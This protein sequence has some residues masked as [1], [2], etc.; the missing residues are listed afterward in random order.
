MEAVGPDVEEGFGVGVEDVASDNPGEED[1]VV[2]L[3]EL[4]DDL[5]VEEGQGAGQDGAALRLVEQGDAVEGGGVGLEAPAEVPDQRLAAGG[6]LVE[7]ESPR[8]AD[9]VAR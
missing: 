8:G 7:R 1:Q 4:G 6:E 3:I 9:P 2:A 5:G